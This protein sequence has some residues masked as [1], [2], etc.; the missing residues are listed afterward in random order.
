MYGKAAELVLEV[1]SLDV[2]LVLDGVHVQLQAP[3][4]HLGDGGGHLVGADGDVAVG[5]LEHGLHDLHAGGGEVGGIA[6]LHAE[7]ESGG[8]GVADLIADSGVGAVD[9]H[10]GHLEA[11]Q[12][13]AAFLAQL[14]DLVKVAGCNISLGADPAA[15]HGVDVGIGN[16]LAHVLHVDSAGGN[17]FHAAE[18]AGQGLDGAQT[19][20]DIGG[21]ELQHL[22]AVLQG[23]H[24]LG[25][26]DTAGAD[27][28]AVVAAPG[29]HFLIIA[30]G[31]DELGTALHSQL[32]L[33]QVHHGAGAH[34]HL[35]N[36]SGHSSDG[37]SSGGGILVGNELGAGNLK[38]GRLYGDRLVKL[39]FLCGILSTAIMLAVIPLVIRFVELTDQAGSYLIGMML[40]MAVYMIGRAINTI[41]INGIFAAGGDTLFDMYSLAICMWG[42]AIPLAAA[43]TF[44]FHWPVLVVYACTCLDEVGK[45]PW[46][47]IHYRKYIWVKDLTRDI[48]S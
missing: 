28:N 36:L 39:A 1:D 29:H 47:M 24:D 41:I 40:I 13:L 42:I 18:G 10:M 48:L 31:D 11:Q 7:I 15:A 46:V 43:G 2:I 14:G 45:I 27:G 16:E 5:A 20:I 23:H 33:L 6:L 44:L 34:Q 9:A 12:G 17:E 3:A 8:K 30:G 22:Q 32:A 38:K 4:L 35:G 19:A 37:I 25:G 21:E 26:G